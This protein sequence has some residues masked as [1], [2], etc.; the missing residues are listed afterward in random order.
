M[1]LNP[2][3]LTTDLHTLTLNATIFNM[4]DTYNLAALPELPTLLV[5]NTECENDGVIDEHLLPRTPTFLECF[6]QS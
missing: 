4:T 2:P 3:R 6:H 5:G 1:K